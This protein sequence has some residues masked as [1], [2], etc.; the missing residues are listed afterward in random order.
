MPFGKKCVGVSPDAPT[1]DQSLNGTG[2]SRGGI[3]SVLSPT[4]LEYTEGFGDI[5]DATDPSGDTVTRVDWVDGVYNP[6][7]TTDGLFVLLCDSAGTFSQVFNDNY[8]AATRRDF[9]TFGAFT[10]DGGALVSATPFVVSGNEPLQQLF[11]LLAC[12]GTIRC[13]GL[14]LSAAATDLTAALSS[15]VIHATGAGSQNGDRAQNLTPINGQAPMVFRTLLGKQGTDDIQATGVANI[16]PASYDDGSGVLVPITGSGK[17]TIQYVFLLP[18]PNVEV[19]VMYGQTVYNSLTDAVAAGAED[20]IVVPDLYARNALLLGRIAVS[21]SATNLADPTQARFLAGAR[22]G[23]GL[24]GGSAAG[25]GGGGNVIGAASSNASEVPTFADASG[26]VLD[27]NSDVSIVN[28]IIKRLGLGN[29]VLE[30]S[31]S[32]PIELSNSTGDTDVLVSAP[33]GGKSGFSFRIDEV[34]VGGVGA[35][36][37]GYLKFGIGSYNNSQNGVIVN[38]NGWVSVGNRF[39]TSDHLNSIAF[40]IFTSDRGFMPPV[41]TNAQRNSIIGVTDGLTVFNSDTKEL[42]SYNESLSAWGKAKATLYGENN[43]TLSATSGTSYVPMQIGTSSLIGAV[44]FTGLD[45]RTIRYNGPSSTFSIR[46]T[47]NLRS[48]DGQATSPYRWEVAVSVNGSAVLPTATTQVMNGNDGSNVVLDLQN[49][50]LNT[51]DAL[52]LRIRQTSGAIE[53]QPIAKNTTLEVKE[54]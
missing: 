37:A 32:R 8:D 9:L 27:S 4:E 10:I 41:L 54:Y 14:S 42:Q 25:G 30:A 31:T 43:T 12:L 44:G 47:T 11:D 45:S 18:S 17:A 48:A 15:G 50:T 33:A 5:V 34:G 36:N 49:I 3:I 1:K 35:S 24:A 46:L 29:L 16:D 53:T 13:S 52:S 21:Q 22:F 40:G 6:V 39:L 7:L 28:G 38:E 26:L 20:P 51:N 2:V 19:T 23:S